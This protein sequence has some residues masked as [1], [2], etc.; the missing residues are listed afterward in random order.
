MDEFCARAR[1]CQ[2]WSFL[3]FFYF[4][5]H[6]HLQI[7]YSKPIELVPQSMEVQPVWAASSTSPPQSSKTI[8]DQCRVQRCSSIASNPK[9]KTLFCNLLFPDHP[10]AKPHP[11]P[12]VCYLFIFILFHS[13]ISLWN[14]PLIFL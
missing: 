3:V 12:C 5:N 14:I 13:Q 4:N 9:I 2:C 11:N 1:R 10:E 6:I 8:T 7:K